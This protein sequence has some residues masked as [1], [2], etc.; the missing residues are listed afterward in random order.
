MKFK[1]LKKLTNLEREKRFK[2]L[3]MEL[4]KADISKTGGK[5]NKIKKVLARINTLNSLKKQE[6]IK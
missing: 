3:K 6:K 1:E 5:I 2:E 4:I